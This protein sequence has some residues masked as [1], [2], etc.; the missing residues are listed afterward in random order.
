MKKVLI[1][2]PAEKASEVADNIGNNGFVNLVSWS[3]QDGIFGVAIKMWVAYPGDKEDTLLAR[4]Q[5]Y[6]QKP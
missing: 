2:F 6:I 5:P 4:F 1:K 3:S